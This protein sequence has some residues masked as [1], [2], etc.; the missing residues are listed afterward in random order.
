MVL[1]YI[2]GYSNL[3]P[4]TSQNFT[5]VAA[6]SGSNTDER[7]V[8]ERKIISDRLKIKGPVFS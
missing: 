6:P 1:N 8:Q 7:V 4:L 3:L 5:R 2:V